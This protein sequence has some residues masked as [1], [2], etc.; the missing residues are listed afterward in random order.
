MP[1]IS[2]VVVDRS[3]YINLNITAL[4][5]FLRMYCIDTKALVFMF[6]LIK[7]SWGSNLT[8]EEQNALNNEK[9][10][11]IMAFWHPRSI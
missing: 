3:L 5:V 4:F 9:N 11:C 2:K 1:L 8:P 7:G 10:T 6:N